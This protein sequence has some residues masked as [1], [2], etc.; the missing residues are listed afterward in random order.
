MKSKLKEYQSVTQNRKLCVP[1]SA[2]IK[3]ILQFINAHYKIGVLFME[4]LYGWL[5]YHDCWTL[6]VLF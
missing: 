3:K 6:F 5:L 4:Y 2:N 1:E